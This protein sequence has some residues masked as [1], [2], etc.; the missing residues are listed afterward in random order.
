MRSISYEQWK[1]KRRSSLAAAVL[2]ENAFTK[3][4]AGER[5]RDP[6]KEKLLI[7]LE[8]ARRQRYIESG[9]LQILAPRKWRWRIDFKTRP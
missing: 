7:R 3:R 6:E 9:K 5:E 4:V 1:E 2:V 8:S